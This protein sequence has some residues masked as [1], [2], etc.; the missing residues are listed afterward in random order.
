MDVAVRIEAGVVVFWGVG[1][2]RTV[3]VRV[4]MR[5]R[6]NFMLTQVVEAEGYRM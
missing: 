5:A 6:E 1:T 2:A 3:A 4:K